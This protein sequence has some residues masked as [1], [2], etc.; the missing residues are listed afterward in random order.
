M[1]VDEG[2][3]IESSVNVVLGKYTKKWDENTYSSKNLKRL[4][5]KGLNRNAAQKIKDAIIDADSFRRC[6]DKFDDIDKEDIA[7][8]Y[9]L[10]WKRYRD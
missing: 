2:S 6:V 5:Y 8:S 4:Y 3:S 7:S 9:Q 10:G 1:S